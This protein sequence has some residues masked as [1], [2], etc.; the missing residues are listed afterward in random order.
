MSG[1]ARPNLH[2][3]RGIF[4]FVATQSLLLSCQEASPLMMAETNISS[5][6]KKQHEICEFE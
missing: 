1:T 6:T 4:D 2:R 3:L 5:L